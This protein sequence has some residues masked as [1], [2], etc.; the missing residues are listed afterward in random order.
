VIRQEYDSVAWLPSRSVTRTRNSCRPTAR[1]VYV[2]GEEHGE[3]AVPSSEQSYVVP[4]S[5]EENSKVAL[6]LTVVRS[7]P[8]SIVDSGGVPAGSGSIHQTC[9]AGERSTLREMSTARTSKV[10]LWSGARPSYSIGEAHGA[11]GAWSSEHW[12][13]TVLALSLPMNSNFAVALVLG[14]GGDATR[15][16]SGAI[17]S[18]RAPGPPSHRIV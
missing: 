6:V 17:W 16:V 11:N 3:N 9:L 12:N 14:F 18:V 8:E 5:L 4:R 1:P 13:S 2:F 10:W 15:I 7:G